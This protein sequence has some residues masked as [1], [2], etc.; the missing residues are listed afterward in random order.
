[1]RVFDVKLY[2]EVPSVSVFRLKSRTLTAH[3]IDHIT[4]EGKEQHSEA[5]FCF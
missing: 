4:K 3:Q 5:R 2:V 1:M